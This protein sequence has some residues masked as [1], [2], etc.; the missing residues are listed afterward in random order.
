M[1]LNGTS[2]RRM[3]PKMRALLVPL[4]GAPAVE[5]FRSTA[6]SVDLLAWADVVIG[7]QP[8]HTDRLL[9]TV[10]SKPTATLAAWLEDGTTR[11]KDP[12]FDGS[13]ALHAL[14]IQQVQAAMPRLYREV[15][16]V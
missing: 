12:H 2:R 3:S 8:S 6:W 7:F 16:G 5:A 14:A 13:G 10:M 15:A 9:S 1:A 4:V 11:I